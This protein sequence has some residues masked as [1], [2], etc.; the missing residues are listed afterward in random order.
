MYFPSATDTIS[1]KKVSYYLRVDSVLYCIICKRKSSTCERSVALN[2]YFKDKYHTNHMIW[3]IQLC[4]I[5][6]CGHFNW[7]LKSMV[8][9]AQKRILSTSRTRSL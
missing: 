3:I 8:V 6:D 2:D 4:Y 1:N 9:S 7:F 5:F